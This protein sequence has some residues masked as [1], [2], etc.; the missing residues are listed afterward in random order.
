MNR[1]VI[2]YVVILLL[3]FCLEGESRVDTGA[4]FLKFIAGARNAGMGAPFVA[5]AD[6]PSTLHYN[7]AGMLNLKSSELLLMY[8][9]AVM[10]SGYEYLGFVQGTN[11]RNYTWGANLLY[12]HSTSIPVTKKGEGPYSAGE[13]IGEM[14]Y[15]DLG[16]GLSCASKINK[17]LYLGLTT[18]YLKRAFIFKGVPEE[19]LERLYQ[20]KRGKKSLKGETFCFDCGILYFITPN[21]R[22]GGALQ[23]WGPK[24][25]FKDKEQAD[26]LPHGIMLGIAWYTE[27]LKM[28]VSFQRHLGLSQEVLALPPPFEGIKAKAEWNLGLEYWLYKILALRIGY[29]SRE[30]ALF[31]ATYGGGIKL[32]DNIQF[33][34]AD[35]PS[36]DLGR[37]KQGS[38]ILKF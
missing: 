19:E 31:G 7:P 35:V 16:I 24:V 3:N 15:R 28:G 8:S 4:D 23:N 27:D 38:I 36:G 34:F 22:V 9:Q 20:L 21:L 33:D 18:K 6:D 11:K 37:I 26:H 10:D 30:G 5:I 13:V 25:K 29:Y 1:R 2:F 12:Y 14:D 32:G 17:K